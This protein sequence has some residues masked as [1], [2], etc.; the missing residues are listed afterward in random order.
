MQQIKFQ[1]W[2]KHE[3][4]LRSWEDI[5]SH[6]YNERWFIDNTDKEYINCL[7]TDHHIILL[8]FTGLEDKNGVE[9]YKGFKV[10]VSGDEYYSN[11]SVCF[12]DGDWSFTGEVKFS[13]FMWLVAD[14]EWIPFCD[15][16]ANDL[17]VEVVGHIYEN[18]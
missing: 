10:K 12:D 2:D 16:M 5:L 8:P 7:F 11:N 9:I 13:S 4:V 18:Q 14:T 15:I 1:A 6:R 3:K 17:D